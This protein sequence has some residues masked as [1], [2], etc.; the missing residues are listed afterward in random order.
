MRL[1]KKMSMKEFLFD[2]A[3]YKGVLTLG[4]PI[5][6]QNLLSSSA[7]LI[8]T[9]MVGQLGEVPLSAVGM[10]G[11]WSFFMFLFYFGFSSGSSVFFSQYWG[12]KDMPRIR[13]TYSLGFLNVFIIAVLFMTIGY[14]FPETVIRVFTTD[15][16]VVLEGAKYLKIAVFGYIAQ[17]VNTYGCTLLRSTEEVKLP[18]VANIIAVLTNTFFNWVLIYGHFGVPPMGVEGAALATVISAWVCTIIVLTVSYAKKNLLAM[19]I[20][21]F[22]RIRMSTVKRFYPVVLPVVF[23][24]SLWALATMCLNMVYGRLGTGNFSA[25]TVKNTIENLAFTFFIGLSSACSVMVGK[26]IGAGEYERGFTDARRFG[27]VS[28]VLALLLSIVLISLRVPLTNLFTLSDSVKITAQWLIIANAC[29]YPMRMFNHMNIVGTF[30]AGG[31]TRTSL[32]M[33][34]GSIW[35]LSVPLVALAGLVWKLPFVFVFLMTAVEELVKFCI[36]LWHLNSG[37]WIKPVTGKT[38]VK[39]ESAA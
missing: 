10:A 35:G 11:Q 29:I 38:A 24:E 31:D 6:A 9:V 36:G 25:M 17:C 20:R 7:S 3:F 13:H 37:R 23:N 18:M 27:L 28:P 8:D 4:L 30:R 26:S 21:E 22:F 19:P 39:E 15:E 12:V 1:S 33:D 32:F 14:L 2:R 5:A 16:A 34:A